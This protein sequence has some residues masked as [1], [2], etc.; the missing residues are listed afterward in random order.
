[1]HHKN[2]VDMITQELGAQAEFYAAFDAMREVR[3]AVLKSL[4]ELR[5]QGEIKHSLDAAVKLYISSDF[6]HQASVGQLFAMIQELNQDVN[7]FLKEYFIVSQIQLVENA[8]GMQQVA[9]GIF[10]T[11]SKAVGGKC[12]RCWQW[13]EF[14]KF[15]EARQLC[16]RC[17]RA[18]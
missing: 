5:G 17:T 18:L 13:E 8:D 9:P 16:Q 4:E 2:P 3:G 1:M 11:T 14:S 15:D 10:V 12:A 7:L 6:K